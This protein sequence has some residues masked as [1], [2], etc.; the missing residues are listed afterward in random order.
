[1]DKAGNFFVGGTGGLPDGD[2]GVLIGGKPLEVGDF[3]SCSVA[4]AGWNGWDLTELVETCLG[5]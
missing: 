5:S 2:N 1:M 3:G 4:V